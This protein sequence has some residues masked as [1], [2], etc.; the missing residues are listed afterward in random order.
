M[1]RIALLGSTGSI[2]T[3]ALDVIRGLGEPYELVSLAAGKRWEVVLEQAREFRPRKVAMYDL[4]A[5]EKLKE[6]LSGTGIEVLAGQ[7]G[8]C[9]LAADPA[10]EV[11]ILGISGAAALPAAVAAV[12]AGKRVGLANKEAMVMAGEIMAPLVRE[13]GAEIIPVDSEHSALFQ[14]LKSGRHEEVDKLLL[15]ASGGPFRAVPREEMRDVTPEQALAHPTWNMGR[16]ITID[17]AT[18]MNKSLEIIEARWLFDMPADKI[19]VVIHPQSIVHSMVQ[20][21]DG[22]VIG[23]MGLPD[24]RVPIQLAITYPERKKSPVSAP[25]WGA[26]KTLTFDEPD[27]EKFPS[28]GMGYRA[29]REGGTLGA[30]MNAANEIAVDRFFEN[31]VSFLEIFELVSDVMDLHEVVHR[32]SLEEVFEADRWARAKARVWNSR[33]P[34]RP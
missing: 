1:H 22:S 9:E 18:M 33:G 21:C 31:E 32:P 13:S 2:G 16:K 34:R 11:V 15:T 28:L 7:E 8:I 6:G 4:A 23:Q 14:S 25:D 29:A 5:A 10:A 3:S 30:V 19:E 17:S 24:M 12:Q 20:Y 27:P 26:V